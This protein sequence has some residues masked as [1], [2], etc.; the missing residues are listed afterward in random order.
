MNKSCARHAFR[1]H[2][3]KKFF[4]FSVMALLFCGFT[5]TANAQRVGGVSVNKPKPQQTQGANATQQVNPTPSSQSS[6]DDPYS[7]LKLDEYEDYIQVILSLSKE[8][9]IRNHTEISK[10]MSKAYDVKKKLNNRVDKMNQEQKNRFAKLNTQ[11]DRYNSSGKR[12]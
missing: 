10:Y 12:K 8:D 4:I 6:I 5:I 2:T 9:K 11:L 7:A 3:M 1:D